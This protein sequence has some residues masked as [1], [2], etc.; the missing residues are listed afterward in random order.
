MIFGPIQI[1]VENSSR[2]IFSNKI[3]TIVA[4]NVFLI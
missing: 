3:L 2:L 4:Q 1:F